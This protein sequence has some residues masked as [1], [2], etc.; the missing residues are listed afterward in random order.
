MASIQ[1][2]IAQW[3]KALQIEVNHLK[4]QGGSRFF[5]SEGKCLRKQERKFTYLF[6][7]ASDDMF[8]DDTPVRIEHRNQSYYGKI[9]SVEG[10]EAVI[11][12]TAFMGDKVEE[13]QLFSEPWEVIEALS[14]R[15]DSMESSNIKL[16]RASRLLS[17][18]TAVKHPV[19][20]IKNAVDEAVLRSR[21]NAATYIWGPPGTGKTFTLARVIAKNYVRGKKILVLAHSN[22]AVDVLMLELAELIKRKLKW[23]PGEIIRYGFSADPNLLRHRDILTSRLVENSSMHTQQKIQKLLSERSRLKK[24][25]QLDT[26]NRNSEELVRVEEELN[27]LRNVIK[28]EESKFVDQASVLGVTLAKAAMDPA[29]YEREYDLVVVDEASMAS[30]PQIGYASSLGKKIVI[31]GDFRQLPPIAMSE[32]KLV[33]FWLKRDIFHAAKIVQAVEQGQ[34]HPHLFMLKEQRRMHPDISSFTNEFIY[35]HRVFDHETVAK[36]RDEI[37]NKPPFLNEAAALVDLS[38]MA[39]YSLKEASSDSRF[40]ILS[41]LISMQLILSAK[42]NGINSIGFIAPY[43][44]QARFITACLMDLMP[45]EAKDSGD[46]GITAATVHK[47]QGSERDMVIFDNVDS[48]PQQRAGVLLTDETSDRLINVAITRAKGKFINIADRSYIE[49]RVSKKRAVNALIDHLSRNNHTYTRNEIRTVLQKPQHANLRW[50]GDKDYEKLLLEDLSNAK[51]ILISVPNP[52]KM[53]KAIW[54]VLRHADFIA[55]VTF[56]TPKKDGIPL[57]SFHHVTRDLVMPFLIIDGNTLWI[58][59]P[60]MA[61]NQHYRS[62]DAQDIT[63]RLV[64]KRAVKLLSSFLNLQPGQYTKQQVQE[65]L[66]SYRPSYSLGQYIKSWDQCHVCRSRRVME[67][68]ANGRIILMCNYCGNHSGITKTILQKYI[69]YIDLKCRTCHTAL[70]ASGSGRNISAECFSCNEKIDV[71]SLW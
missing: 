3:K 66:V 64:S 54:N 56:V 69:D 70:E 43:K 25:I 12:V 36:T 23:K 61:D 21:Y 37:V 1:E 52:S 38:N 13:A 10:F 65:K 26:R 53:D 22:A 57:A 24:L 33:D 8:P 48:F 32:H 44:A 6:L 28:K 58:G 11:E 35:N 41:A 16:K 55:E 5:L 20:K 4:N 14:R 17:G 45:E 7:L 50:F 19:E 15:L 67:P 59:T 18:K 68:A 2:I 39:A 34:E 40:N 63:C 60:V 71:R 29:V 42:K 31:C 47:F 27:K 46:K 62:Y 9:V 51:E 30:I 49:S